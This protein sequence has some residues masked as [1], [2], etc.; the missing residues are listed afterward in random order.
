MTRYDGQVWE[1]VERLDG[2]CD[3]AVKR[4]GMT[5]RDAL[6]PTD[7]GTDHEMPGVVYHDR[8]I[9][10]PGYEATL[11]PHPTDTG[12]PETVSIEIDAVGPRSAWE[13]FDAT[14]SWDVYALEAGDVAAIAWMTDSEFHTEEAGQFATKADAVAAGRFSFGVFVPDRQTWEGHVASITET[15]AAA[16]LK[17]DDG[18]TYYP[19]DQP[20]L[21]DYVESTP[22]SLRETA[23]AP[24]YLGVHGL[25]LSVTGTDERER[26]T[27]DGW[28]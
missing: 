26:Y 6:E 18:T 23:D 17:H 16:F 8:G 27:D 15:D 1:T 28:L 12:G 25:V 10:V 13:T 21:Y 3:L 4:G 2:L 9:R 20:A 5:V 24:A 14:R 19:I 7:V 22:T 11:V